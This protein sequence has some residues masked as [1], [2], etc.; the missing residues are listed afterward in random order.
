M[1]EFV[2]EPGCN[3]NAGR[4][5]SKE[6][7]REMKELLKELEHKIASVFRIFRQKDTT[8][9]LILGLSS[10]FRNLLRFRRPLRTYKGQNFIFKEHHL[11]IDSYHKQP[12]ALEAKSGICKIDNTGIPA[13]RAYVTEAG[14]SARR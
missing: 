8:E 11:I 13:A 3:F 10:F 2:R 1:S 4:T 5:H 14:K 9:K 7:A 6:K 12:T